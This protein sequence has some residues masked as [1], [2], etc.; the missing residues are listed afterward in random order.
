MKAVLAL[1]AVLTV[2]TFAQAQYQSSSNYC[3]G[4]TACVD[5]Y[6]NPIGQISCEVMG[7]QAAAGYGVA[8]SNSCQ[9]F[10]QPYVSVYCAGYQIM[11]NAYGQYV[12]QWNVQSYRCPGR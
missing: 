4:Y 9:W 5:Y 6:G 2:S 1:F 7:Y 12:A 8:A 10:V 11:Q 3:S